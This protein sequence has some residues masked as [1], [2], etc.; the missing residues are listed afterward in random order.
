MQEQINKLNQKPA[1]VDSTTTYMNLK[2]SKLRNMLDRLQPRQPSDQVLFVSA[3]LMQKV[4]VKRSPQF[5]DL[6]QYRPRPFWDIPPCW[7]SGARLDVMGVTLLARGKLNYR[8][9]T[10]LVAK[11]PSRPRT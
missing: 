1:D 7:K 5:G 2:E 4:E 11:A 9:R 8:Y 3:T 6:I 10:D